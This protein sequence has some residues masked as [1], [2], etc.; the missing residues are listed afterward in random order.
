[1]RLCSCP[2]RLCRVKAK[3]HYTDPTRQ[4]P[5]T[6]SDTRVADKVRAHCR[7]R[8]KFHYTDTDPTGPGSGRVRVRVVE[9]SSSPTMCADFV[10]DPGIRQSPRTLSGR[11]RVVE[12]SFYAT[13]SQRATAQSHTATLSSCDKVVRQNRA[14]KSQVLH[15][16]NKE[17]ASITPNYP[18]L[19]H[20]RRKLHQI[21]I[22]AAL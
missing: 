5:R 17:A 7:R 6:L 2:L 22:R 13:K 21:C 18:S 1:V 11:V 8:A 9:F 14:I 10:G 19:A 3:F 20:C 16:S 4:S 15:R 12:F